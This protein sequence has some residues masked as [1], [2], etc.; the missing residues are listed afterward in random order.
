VQI[1][2]EV[3]AVRPSTDK[4]METYVE[5]YVHWGIPSR[6]EARCEDEGFEWCYFPQGGEYLSFRVLRM[7]D[8]LMFSGLS[9]VLKER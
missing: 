3:I 8:L 5:V 6:E 2:I 1:E 7:L 9:R 4:Y